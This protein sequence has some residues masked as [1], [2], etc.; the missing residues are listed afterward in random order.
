MRILAPGP[1]LRSHKILRTI[2]IITCQHVPAAAPR[3]LISTIPCGSRTR[4]LSRRDSGICCTRVQPPRGD[5][6]DCRQTVC[7][8][9]CLSALIHPCPLSLLPHPSVVSDAPIRIGIRHLRAA[10]CCRWRSSPCP[11]RPANLLRPAHV[12]FAVECS[13]KAPRRAGR[14]TG[15][16]TERMR[17]L[18]SSSD[19]ARVPARAARDSAARRRSRQINTA[20]SELGLT[21]ERWSR[22]Q[23]RNTAVD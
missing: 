13:P 21:H 22:V 19:T 8:S 3:S 7:T 17:D 12:S 15:R 9:G 20:G 10:R 11:R 16:G 2:T 5:V 18:T 23:G 14:G 6:H 1:Q 4:W